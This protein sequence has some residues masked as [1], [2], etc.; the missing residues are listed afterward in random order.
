[1]GNKRFDYYCAY[2]DPDE[3]ASK[4][5]AKR[6]Y[7]VWTA[8]PATTA[9]RAA[10][11]FWKE[12]MLEEEW[13]KKDVVLIGIMPGGLTPAMKKGW[14]EEDEEVEAAAELEA[15]QEDGDE[16]DLEDEDED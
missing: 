6:L 4:T 12:V 10:T 15:E 7:S 9:Q 11:I 3:I 5:P 8:I 1:M 14:T 2:I 13:T 16:E